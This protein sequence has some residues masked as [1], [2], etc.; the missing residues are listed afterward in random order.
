ML[1]L[2]GCATTTVAVDPLKLTPQSREAAVAVSI[3]SNTGEV[4]GFSAIKLKRVPPPLKPGESA[5]PNEYFVMHRVA[6]GMARDTSLFIGA[7]PAGEYRFDELSDGKTMKVLRMW[8]GAPLLGTFHVEA[9]K[10]TDLGR[11]I[12]TPVNLH[13]VFGR[14]DS[15]HANT[16]L[17]QRFAPEYAALFA[18]GANPGWGEP[19]KEQ[20]RVEEYARQRPVGADCA[21]EMPDGS[22]AFASRLGTVLLR[23]PYGRWRVL[24]SPGLESVLCV[25]PVD[26][27][28]AELIAV[29]EFG[30]LLR[31][32]RGSDQLLPLAPGNLPPG[33][34][35]HLAGNP[36]LG[37][38]LLHQKGND[39]TLFHS[40]Q[41]EGG[42]WQPLRK[43]SVALS[44]WSGQNQLWAW[45]DDAGTGY[46]S[47]TGA[48]HRF[49]Y[50]SGA[51]TQTSTPE[52]ARLLAYRRTQGGTTS[53]LTS[54]GGGLGGVFA[55]VYFSRDEGKTWTA[56]QTPFNVKIS[57]LLQVK[58]G[59]MLM[60]GGVFSK[61]E[62][63][64]SSDDGKTWSHY[65]D[66]ELS[67][68][69][70]LLS[71]GDVLDTDAGQ[72]GLFTIRSS[73]NSGKTWQ[74]EYSNFDRQAYDAQQKKK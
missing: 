43:E 68:T 65:A 18:A 57:P 17:M 67:R 50:A 48:I 63:Q 59:R 9:G 15:G 5:P 60:P 33:N 23:S 36:K 25:L 26:L 39:V 6:D 72:F 74:V 4:S 29:G 7:L 20:D 53:I 54:P 11:L 24:R 3:T 61:A 35:L 13:V 28:N 34:L 14:S 64:I 22:V 27:P 56:V 40:R 10:P 37:W 16:E 42:D 69:L 19:R 45:H 62:L 55:S 52:N 73:V 41:L 30:T 21:S 1:L 47:S 8:S 38:Y 46:A 44:F 31:K 2:G 12:V 58:D 70:M 71:S 66:Y 49:D 32:A 51:W